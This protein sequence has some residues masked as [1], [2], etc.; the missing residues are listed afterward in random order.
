MLTFYRINVKNLHKSRLLFS[1]V[2]NKH[3]NMSSSRRLSPKRTS[4]KNILDA[5]PHTFSESDRTNYGWVVYI[6]DN[7]KKCVKILSTMNSLKMVYKKIV[8]TNPKK[9]QEFFNIDKSPP[10]VFFNGTF[11]GDYDDF[12]KHVSAL[13]R[14]NLIDVPSDDTGLSYYPTGTIT[15][16]ALIYLAEKFPNACALYTNKYDE[17][18]RRYAIVW[19]SDDKKLDVGRLFPTKLKKCIAKNPRFILIYLMI[20]YDPQNGHANCL[21]YDTEKKEMERFEPGY[22]EHTDIDRAILSYFNNKFPGLIEKYYKPIDY[23]SETRFQEDQELENTDLPND[24]GGFCLAW[25]IWYI[26]MRLTYPDIPRNELIILATKK[27]ALHPDLYTGYIRNYAA[28]LRKY[29]EKLYKA[30]VQPVITGLVLYSKKNQDVSH[31]LRIL[32]GFKTEYIHEILPN[33]INKNFLYYNHID[34]LPSLKYN[35]EDITHVFPENLQNIV[36]QDRDWFIYVI[37]SEKYINISNE[38][39]DF[40]VNNLPDK[41]QKIKY[42][43]IPVQFNKLFDYL[44]SSYSNQNLTHIWPKVFKDGVYVGSNMLEIFE[45]IRKNGS[46]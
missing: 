36:P 7:C 21:I 10:W 24:P 30:K 37:D 16:A 23:W 26:D 19:Y 20:L 8:I 45:F 40:I 5:S 32:D 18:Q 3:C 17:D 43:I 29:M 44:Y 34:K 28:F 9:I 46:V 35:N 31:F 38:I 12:M 15:N 25:T 33:K 2:L 1:S 4:Q 13:E 42:L 27:I 22:A 6:T 39:Y 14:V 41:S 11:F